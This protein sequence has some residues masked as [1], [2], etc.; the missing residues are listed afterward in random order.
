MKPCITSLVET[1]ELLGRYWSI[2]GR[3]ANLLR[4]V[5]DEY[6]DHVNSPADERHAREAPPSVRIL[7]DMRRCAYD[8]DLLI[9]R[10]PKSTP[11]R[12]T[13]TELPLEYLDVFDFFNVP[14]LPISDELLLATGSQINPAFPF[15]GG[16]ELANT[17][18]LFDAN[19]D[20]LND[21]SV[22]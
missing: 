7:A 4:R 10:Q 22:M 11:I 9:S 5:L 8:L 2:A 1:L 14:R 18:F 16:Q 13:T 21:S 12:A 19:V 20:W 17:N 3:Y 6:H 15:Q